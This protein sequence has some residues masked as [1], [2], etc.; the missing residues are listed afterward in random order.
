M[1]TV[2]DTPFE[3]PITDKTTAIEL[4][5]RIIVLCNGSHV[6]V[7][8]DEHR[9]TSNISASGGS[10]GAHLVV[11]IGSPTRGT[12]YGRVTNGGAGVPYV[13]LNSSVG[14][15]YTYTDADGYYALADLS[16]GS[17]T[18]T[19]L[20]YGNSFTPAASVLSVLA[21]ANTLNIAANPLAQVSLVATADARENGPNGAFTLTR[22]VDYPN[23]PTSVTIPDGQ[24]GI[25]LLV[26]PV[27]DSL[28]EGS[29]NITVNIPSGGDDREF[30]HPRRRLSLRDRHRDQARCERDE[31]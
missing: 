10:G 3:E 31:P 21:G 4:E 20:L 17:Q 2:L 27:D 29:E 6:R 26:T 5:G 9:L 8:E 13:L 16:T 24:A 15:R 1:T 30:T 12:L 23:L 25:T 11:V 14:S 7:L 19:P 22:G 28:V 18:I